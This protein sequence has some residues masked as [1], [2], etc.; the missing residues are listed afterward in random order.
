MNEAFVYKW[1][2]DRGE[3]YIGVHTGTPEDGYIGSGL[4]HQRGMKWRD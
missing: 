4:K 1:M 3:Y 2:N